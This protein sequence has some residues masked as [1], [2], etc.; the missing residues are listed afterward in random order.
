MV[1][2]SI[3]TLRHTLNLLPKNDNSGMKDHKG[4][5]VEKDGM[6]GAA[7]PPPPPPPPTINDQIG[8]PFGKHEWDERIKLLKTEL[9]TWHPELKK[10]M[11]Y[12]HH[13]EA[14]HRV[15]TGSE[16]LNSVLPKVSPE[17]RGKVLDHL[18]SKKEHLE[19]EISEM[20]KII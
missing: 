12:L 13:E 8:N 4:K 16:K 1:F 5:K 7:P 18:R 17:H 3:Y 19:K 20:G 14:A 11:G 2:P 15:L 10:N 9:E 6:M